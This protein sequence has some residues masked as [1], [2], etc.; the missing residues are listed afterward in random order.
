V[1]FARSGVD[2]AIRR[3]D[4]HW[5]RQLYNQKIC[6]EWIGPVA[7]AAMASACCTAPPAPLPGPP[8]CA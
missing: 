6:D 1:D 4:F 3:D 8:G 7:A 2:L 5:D